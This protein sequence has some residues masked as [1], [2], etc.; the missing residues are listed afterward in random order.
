MK[1]PP[2]ITAI[3]SILN[4]VCQ[5]REL[6]IHPTVLTKK[7]AHTT[8]AGAKI[9]RSNKKNDKELANNIIRL[10]QKEYS[11]KMYITVKFQ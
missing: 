6:I 2:T 3:V 5:Y 11:N 1:Q 9:S 7:T 10:I 8:T 4:R